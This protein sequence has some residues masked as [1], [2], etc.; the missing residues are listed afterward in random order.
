[1]PSRPAL[2]NQRPHWEINFPDPDNWLTI[3]EFGVLPAD[4]DFDGFD[5]PIFTPACVD[6]K[7]RREL[8]GT[9]KMVRAAIRKRFPT[10]LELRQANDEYL[11]IL[12]RERSDGR[13]WT[14]SRAVSA[15]Q[16]LAAQYE[17]FIQ[18]LE[19]AVDAHAKGTMDRGWSP[20]VTAL[21]V[22]AGIPIA[23]RPDK[24]LIATTASELGRSG[25]DRRASYDPKRKAKRDVY[26][27]WK[28]WRAGILKYE[29]KN[30]FGNAMRKRFPVLTSV[31]VIAGWCR[32][33]DRGGTVS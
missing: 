2:L 8:L 1:M 33:W 21:F 28:Q 5:H 32:Q 22:V 24:I 13:K 14:G 16:R 15:D 23:L 3:P 7:W 19:W 26:E 9:V 10:L 11:T 12:R 4:V 27:C 18:S 17:H 29:G 20:L 30:H 31:P 25:G 6:V